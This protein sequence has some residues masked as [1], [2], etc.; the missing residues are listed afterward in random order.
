MKGWI[1]L[2]IAH[3]HWQRNNMLMALFIFWK[4]HQV[5]HWS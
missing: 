1:Y 5:C 3:S 4:N 2:M